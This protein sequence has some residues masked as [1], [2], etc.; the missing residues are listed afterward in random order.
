MQSKFFAS[1]LAAA[2][3]AIAV[4]TAPVAT[5]TMSMSVASVAA[6]AVAS[7]TAVTLAVVS[8]SAQAG[9]R[10]PRY[11]TIVV[12]PSYDAWLEALFGEDGFEVI[13]E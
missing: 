7:A 12:D 6:P 4:V 5:T 10:D 3:A 11:D 2:A 8:T 1:P 13:D 9:R